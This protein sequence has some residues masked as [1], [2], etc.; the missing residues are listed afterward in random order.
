MLSFPLS[1]SYPLSHLFSLKAYLELSALA[2]WLMD[3]L[4]QLLAPVVNAPA[5]TPAPG[6]A[7]AACPNALA[8]LER[9]GRAAAADVALSGGSRLL[10]EVR[11]LVRGV[12]LDLLLPQGLDGL[13]PTTPFFGISAHTPA[14]VWL[15]FLLTSFAF[16]PHRSRAPPLGVFIPARAPWPET[17]WFAASSRP[18]GTPS[19][20]SSPPTDPVQSG[21]PP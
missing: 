19:R 2:V 3:P 10:T 15:L 11:W 13:S 4:A 20:C 9:L 12:G 6:V 5:L 1:L 8:W 16:P 18:S 17:W 21:P 7:A 14:G